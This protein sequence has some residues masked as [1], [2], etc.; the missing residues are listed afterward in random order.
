MQQKGLNLIGEDDL[1]MRYSG[2]VE[3][4]NQINRLR[5]RHIAIIIVVHNQHRRAPGRE[6]SDRGE[7]AYRSI[8]CE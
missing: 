3:S 1:F 8:S 5:D 6:G 2:G 7:G 4:L